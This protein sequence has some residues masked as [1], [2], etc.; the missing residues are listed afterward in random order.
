MRKYYFKHITKF[1]LKQNFKNVLHRGVCLLVTPF[2]KNTVFKGN[3]RKQLLGVC[4]TTRN[5]HFN[6]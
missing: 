2:S 6:L 5:D 4:Q 1:F 3:K